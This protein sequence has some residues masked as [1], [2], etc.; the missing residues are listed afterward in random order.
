MCVFD[1]AAAK[2]SASK[3]LILAPWTPLVYLRMIG[4]LAISQSLHIKYLHF[5]LYLILC[6]LYAIF[7]MGTNNKK[8]KNPYKVKIV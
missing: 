1:V 7:Q 5:Q 6:G 3:N 2:S 4:R 8:Q